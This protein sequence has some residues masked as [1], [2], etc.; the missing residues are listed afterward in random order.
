M[1]GEFKV[2]YDACAAMAYWTA[3]GITNNR[4]TAEEITQ[5][6]FLR[7]YERWDT[8]GFLQ[9]PSQ[10]AWIW[11]TA[12]NLALD[13]KRKDRPLAWVEEPPEPAPVPG[14]GPE[15]ALLCKERAQ[16]VWQAVTKL[17]PPL[18]QA[19]LLHYYARVADGDA[20]RA[21]GIPGGTY[22]SRLSRARDMLREALKDEVLNL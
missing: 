14:Q 21:L 22:R 20:A 9:L 16:R 3:Y 7:A 19:V 1:D 5:T 10:R 18:R 11:R 13:G 12:R 8:V 15:E 6:V 17:S 2:L 4:H